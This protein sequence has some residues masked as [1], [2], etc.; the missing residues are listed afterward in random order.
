MK[1]NINLPPSL[2]EKMTITCVEEPN[3]GMCITFDWDDTD[4][5]LAPWTQLNEQ[6][7]RSFVMTALTNR[8]KEDLNAAS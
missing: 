5:E 3:G 2:F 6:E 1:P 8:L 7:Q 4:P